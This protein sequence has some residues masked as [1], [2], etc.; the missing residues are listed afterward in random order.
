M[1]LE[2]L[3]AGLDLKI[4]GGEEP[5]ENAQVKGNHKSRVE[6]RREPRVQGREATL[7][8]PQSGAFPFKP[9]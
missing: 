6:G 3:D 7:I 4:K 8:A 5:L 2:G 9:S 1:T